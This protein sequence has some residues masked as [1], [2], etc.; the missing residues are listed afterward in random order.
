MPQEVKDCILFTSQEREKKSECIR[1]NQ[2]K[3]SIV[4]IKMLCCMSENTS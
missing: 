4:K 2:Y 1:K 3:L